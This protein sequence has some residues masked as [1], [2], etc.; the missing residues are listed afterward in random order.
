MSNRNDMVVEIFKLILL[1]LK[2]V[3]FCV[4]QVI[5][6]LIYGLDYPDHEK[7]GGDTNSD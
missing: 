1:F 4:G 3:C 5:M 7:K 6:Y 2:Y